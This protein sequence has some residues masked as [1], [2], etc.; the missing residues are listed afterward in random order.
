MNDKLKRLPALLAAAALGAAAGGCISRRPPDKP[1]EINLNVK[2]EQEV[3]VRLQR[4]VEQLIHQNPQ[5][6]PTPRQPGGQP[7]MQDA[8]RI[9]ALRSLWRCRPRRRARRRSRA[10]RPPARS[11][12]AMTAISAMPAVL[13]ANAA[14]RGRCDQ[15]PPARALQRGSPPA[16]GVTPQEV[17]ITAGCK[18]AWPRSQVGEAYL[19]AD[20]AWRRRAAGAAAPVPAYCR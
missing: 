18:I 1:I 16:K 14:S 3:L 15:H 12:S 13:P 8:R 7:M 17:G 20:S 11:G 5:A 2:I 4:D 9:P 19:L 6:F 10:R